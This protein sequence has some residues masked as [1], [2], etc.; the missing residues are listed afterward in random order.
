MNFNFVSQKNSEIHRRKKTFN[1]YQTSPE[2]FDVMGAVLLDLD[3][4]HA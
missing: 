2:R 4:R 3:L 1:M